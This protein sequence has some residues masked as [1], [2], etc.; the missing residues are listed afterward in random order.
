MQNLFRHREVLLRSCLVTKDTVRKVRYI[1]TRQ[2]IHRMRQQ[3]RM[4]RRVVQIHHRRVHL[5]RPAH[6]QVRRYNF[7]PRRVTSDQEQARTLPRP[8][9]AGRLRD[10]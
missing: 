2:G 1:E 6:P 4:P 8:D 7:E 9:S 5:S 3:L 10:A